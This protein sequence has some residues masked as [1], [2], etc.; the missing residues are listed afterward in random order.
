M[1]E[2]EI[3]ELVHLLKQNTQHNF[4]LSTPTGLLYQACGRRGLEK[5]WCPVH[6]SSVAPRGFNSVLSPD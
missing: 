1:T 2:T 6:V 4:S 3:Q 5:D